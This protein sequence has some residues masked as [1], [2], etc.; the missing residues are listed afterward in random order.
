VSGTFSARASDLQ[1]RQR[2]RGDAVLDLRQHPDRKARLSDSSLTV[3]RWFCRRP[4]TCRPM[5]VSRLRSRSAMTRWGS[6]P[7]PTLRSAPVMGDDP[8][9]RC[10]PRPRG[11]RPDDTRDGRPVH[12]GAPPVPPATG[13]PHFPCSDRGQGRRKRDG[14]T[15]GGTHRQTMTPVTGRGRSIPKPRDHGRAGVARNRRLLGLG[16]PLPFLFGPL[17]A[18]LVAALAGAPLSNL[19]VISVGART[20]LGVAVGASLTPTWWHGCR[21]W[22]S[23]SRWCRS[24]SP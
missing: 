22:R 6:C 13:T 9:F 1:R 16:L 17:L 21:R 12:N 11:A 7:V 15:R 5:A 8:A 20:I 10:A 18:C 23:R 3:M 14:K 4:R 19:G 2:R 24:S